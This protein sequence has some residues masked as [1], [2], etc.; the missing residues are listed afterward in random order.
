MEIT[1]QDSF[2]DSR[3][4][5]ERINE[6]ED[7]HGDLDQLEKAELVALKGLADNATCD[8]WEDG[9]VLINENCF[10]E[11]CKELCED[12]GDMPENLPWYIESNIDWDGVACDIKMD[13]TE[14]DF[15]GEV[16]FIRIQ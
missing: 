1:N 6:L 4:V 5:I 13:Y 16:Y 3:D 11:Y 12:M 15:D 2:I 7:T 8:E 10:T 14:V 9:E